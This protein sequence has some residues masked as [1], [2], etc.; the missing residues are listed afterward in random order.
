M[1]KWIYF[2]F[3]AYLMI[4]CQPGSKQ[5]VLKKKITVDATETYQ[6]IEGFG[7]NI[8]PAQWHNGKLKPAIDLL[9][10]DLGCTLFRFDC[11]G[12]ANWLDPTRRDSEGKYAQEY[13]NEV[14]SGPDFKDAWE[15]FRYLNS[16]GIEPFFNVSGKV[17][18]E[19]CDPA[20]PVRLTDFDGYAE[21]V[22]T[23][24]NWA[25]NK[26]KLEFHLFAP[27]NETDL[28][29][30]REGPMIISADMVVAI[31]A[32]IAKLKVHGLDGIRLAVTDDAAIHYDRLV[33]IWNDTTMMDE[34]AVF[35]NHNYGNGGEMDLSPAWVDRNS[36]F[37]N[38]RDS[39]DSTPYKSKSLWMTEYGDLDVSKTIEFEIAWRSNRRIMSYLKGGYNAGLIW[40]A[41]DNLHKHDGVWSDYGVLKTDTLAWVYRPKPRFYAARQLFRFVKPGFIRS[42]YRIEYSLSEDHP[43]RN[44]GEP[45]RNVQ[46]LTFVSADRKD[47]TIIGYS[48]VE[49]DVELDI[50]LK[51]MSQ[52]VFSKKVYQFRTSRSEN[53]IQTEVT[54]FEQGS[55]KST[56]KE[57]SIFTITT[58]R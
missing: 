2:L 5:A 48:M 53:C 32:I 33:P 54:D 51:G 15:T 19:L 56:V 6:T 39:L 35:C 44:Y 13:L 36:V 42:G 52:D 31:K 12:L 20:N 50:S 21:M 24:L 47:F 26:E 41:F 9:V 14:Y 57:R 58:V 45:L 8:N 40:D 16:K 7:V 28:N 22:A 29:G 55:V 34:I 25:R 11:I 43:Y 27:F 3:L 30:T 46:I 1:K 49:Q 23:M 10:D 37:R 18:T 38:L 17:R 4:S